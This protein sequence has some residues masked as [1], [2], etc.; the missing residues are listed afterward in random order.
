MAVLITCEAAG[1]SLPHLM[2]GT[3]SPLGPACSS[4]F[5]SVADRYGGEISQ[6]LAE[7]LHAPL[8]RNPFRHDVI[9]VSRSLRHPRLFGPSTKNLSPQQKQ[10]LIETI[11]RPYRRQVQSAIKRIT[12]QFTFAVHISVRTF[13]ASVGGK[14]R[15]TD[16]GLLYDPARP[17]E[18]D[19]CLDWIDELYEISPYLKVRRNY[20][21][22]GTVDSLTKAMRARFP[23]DCYLGIELWLNRAWAARRGRLRDEAIN[24]LCHSLQMTVG[25]PASE[26]A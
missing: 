10:W 25:I 23:A 11:H 8:I 1:E 21:R 14:P 26:A 16:V 22:R 9:D 5:G 15:R 12:Q 4:E 18:V 6:T 13:A 19:F 7:A 24:A 2:V 3:A 20:P 17:N